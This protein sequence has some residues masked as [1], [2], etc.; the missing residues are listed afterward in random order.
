MD[1]HA[2]PTTADQTM[3]PYTIRLKYLSLLEGFYHVF[4]VDFPPL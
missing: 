2:Y 1:T 4:L 3:N